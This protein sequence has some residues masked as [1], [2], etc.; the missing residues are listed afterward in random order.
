MDTSHIFFIMRID[1]ITAI[2]G[3]MDE[4]KELPAQ[5]VLCRRALFTDADVPAYYHDLNPRTQALYFKQ[6]LHVVSDA[7]IMIWL[8]GKVQ[9]LAYDFVAQCVAALDNADVAILK[10]GSRSCVYE[11]L[12]YITS[13]I[14]RGSTYLAARYDHR[15]LPG[16]RREIKATGYPKRAGLNDCSIIAMRRT[17]AVCELMDSWWGRCQDEISFD[18]VWIKVLAWQHGVTIAPIELKPASFKLVKHL[19]VC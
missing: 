17:D 6:Q 15:D 18:Q 3:G 10:H 4:P 8:D 7:D 14:R 12:D 5:S 13:E 9:P 19:K 2:I 11:E 1:V 16:Q